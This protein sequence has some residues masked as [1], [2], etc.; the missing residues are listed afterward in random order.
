M[1]MKLLSSFLGLGDDENASPPS[2]DAAASKAPSGSQDGR[3]PNPSTGNPDLDKVVATFSAM[4][5]S[6][7]RT[8]SDQPYEGQGPQLGATAISP[9]DQQQGKG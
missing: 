7:G 8:T 4:F 6:M 1:V 9:T 5:Q 3:I 2:A